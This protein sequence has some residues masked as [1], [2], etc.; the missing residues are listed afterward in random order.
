MPAD[1]DINDFAH[2]PT[3]DEA[4][5]AK[6]DL[7]RRAK[8]AAEIRRAAQNPTPEPP[9]P[10]PPP[11]RKLKIKLRVP[12]G[13]RAPQE[14]IPPAMPPVEQEDI[15]DELSPP[16]AG[17]KPLTFQEPDSPLEDSAEIASEVEPLEPPPL[18]PEDEKIDEPVSPEPS[19]APGQEPPAA[20]EK[21][22]SPPATKPSK[23]HPQ[24]RVSED[25]PSLPPDKP[26]SSSAKAQ[27]K[28]PASDAGIN[29]PSPDAPPVVL[30]D[31]IPVEDPEATETRFKRLW[32]KIGGRSLALSVAIHLSLFIIAGFIYLSYSENQRIDFLPGGGTQQGEQASQSLE[33]QIN[34]KKTRWLNKRPP[35]QR[36]AVENSLSSISLPDAKPEL[37]DLPLT[38]DFLGAGQM[39]SLGFGKSGAGGGFGSGIGTG[40]KS[41]VTFKPLSMFGKKINGT[42]IAVVLDVSRSMTDYLEGVVK[43]LDRVASGSPVI[44]YYGCGLLRP[45]DDKI[46]ETVQRTQMKDFERFWRI[47]QGEN[48]MLGFSGVDLKKVTFPANQKIPRDDLYRFFARR[49]NT[50]FLDYNG[51]D[52]AWSALLCQEIRNA[53]TVYW[54]SD[55]EDNV[56]ERQMKTVLDNLLVRRQRLYIHPQ[57]HGSSFNQIVSQIVEPSGG[58][59]VEPNDGKKKARK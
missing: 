8:E 49:N 57:T 40:G 53:D 27:D 13:A 15:G 21:T 17:E 41:G 10:A 43:E 14:D 33:N 46:D 1:D 56:D 4:R 39:G 28:E 5:L 22:A 3:V 7:W 31:G 45:G 29:A 20:V 47:W 25:S 59:V 35:M 55:F 37:L 38:K 44:L 30:V 6:Q 9:A 26:A 52:Y 11:K 48:A 36:I 58:D 2:L 50:W 32:D 18:E 23:E 12:P 54:F 34:R 51:M 42:R 24:A 16:A 19:I